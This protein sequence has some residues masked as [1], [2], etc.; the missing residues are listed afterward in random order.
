MDVRFKMNLILWLCKAQNLVDTLQKKKGSVNDSTWRK[1]A[2]VLWVYLKK[3][4]H[5]SQYVIYRITVILTFALQ[6][7]L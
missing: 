5:F 4:K 3:S 6:G 1:E 2:R 7:L